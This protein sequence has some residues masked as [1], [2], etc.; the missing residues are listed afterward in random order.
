LPVDGIVYLSDARSFHRVNVPDLYAGLA[1]LLSDPLRRKLDTVYKNPQATPRETM[2]ALLEAF[3]QGRTVVL[4]DNFEDEVD[5]ETFRI[6][7]SELADAL[8]AVLELPPHAIKIIITTRVAP[9]DLALVEPARQ[10]RLDLD[11][12]LEHPYAENVLRAMD[13]DG[14]I[15]LRNAPE[16]LLAQARERTR[17]Y[18]R[19]LEHLFGI[20]SADR[21]T[22][23][24]EILDNTSRLLPENVVAVLVGEA[25]SRLDST[26]Q[27]VMQTLAIYRYPV[28]PA[29][30]DFLLQPFV[31]GVDSAPVL[32]RL[33]NMQFARRDAGRYYVHQIDRDYAAS[34]VPAGNPADRDEEPLPFSCFALR[35][36]AANWFNLVRK[37]RETWKA[38]DDLAPQFAEFELRF[39]GQDYD[40][41]AS[42]LLDFDYE[43]LLP[44]GHYRLLTE[45][46]ERLQGKI[47]D[48]SLAENSVGN[49]GTGYRMM[50]LYERASA[51]YER[52]LKLAR[53]TKSLLGQAAW[54][55]GLGNCH[56]ELGETEKAIEC[57]LQA[58]EIFRQVAD[59][60]NEAGVL[61]NL[62]NRYADLGQTARAIDYYRQALEIFRDIKARKEEALN[63]C[64]L[65][66]RYD[67]LAQTSQALECYNAALAIARETG[68]RLIEAAANHNLGEAL[69]QQGLWAKATAAFN[70]AIE[71]A[72]DIAA[73]QFQMLSRLG[74]ALAKLYQEE[75]AGARELAEAACRYNF[76]LDNHRSSALLGVVSFRRGDA[77]SA[78]DSFETALR[79]SSELLAGS[80]Q[81]VSALETKALTFCGLA[82]CGDRTLISGAKEAYKAAR[83]L[84][85][86]AGIVTRALRLFDALA[87]ADTGGTLASVR[88][89][90]AGEKVSAAAQ[91]ASG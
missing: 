72:D 8:R 39:A 55:G 53:Q 85:S 78:R 27:R 7:N 54:L 38:L 52:A 50:G 41:A 11:N 80:P 86:D 24:K 32:S 49:L 16:S 9:R 26:A 37:P 68:Y 51:S 56:A 64:N 5:I 22:G 70:H 42:V 3:P 90:A 36:R 79:Q 15:G 89:Y 91:T 82:L 34:R 43:Y 66:N 18:P 77:I 60:R 13:V 48:P 58:L 31:P 2:Q 87:Q 47:P 76:P 63:L 10:R 12:G 21:D 20:L 57:D 73:T 74:L 62:G 28:P 46:H 45:L 35:H 75:L 40:T 67:D 30:V 19:A 69:A 59:R 33:V 84:T 71:I 23:L 6:K 83:T 17:G 65:G 25:F 4:L 81:L 88:S 14:K 61:G 29:A 1:Q 44:W